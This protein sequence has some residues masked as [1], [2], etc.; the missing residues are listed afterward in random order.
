MITDFKDKNYKPK[1]KYKNYKTLSTIIESKD[2]TVI[3]GATST[4]ITSSIT[5][6]GL[7]VVPISA[8]IECTLSLG[9]K[10]LHVDHN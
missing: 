1:K 8:R 10:I 5:G 4:S 9:N 3:T 2:S 7:V 6:I